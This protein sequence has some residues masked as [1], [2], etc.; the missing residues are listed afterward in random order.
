MV[1]GC[2]PQFTLDDFLMWFLT[3]SWNVDGRAW[4]LN[5]LPCNEC[6]ETMLCSTGILKASQ[7]WCYMAIPE[8]REFKK[9]KFS[10][11]HQRHALSMI[12]DIFVIT[13]R[14]TCYYFLWKKLNFHFWFSP[15]FGLCRAT[16]GK[17]RETSPSPHPL[18]LHGAGTNS[19]R[20]DFCAV[21]AVITGR[22]KWSFLE[23][24]HLPRHLARRSVAVVF[25]AK[26]QTLIST[27]DRLQNG[28][29]CWRWDVILR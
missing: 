12:F 4:V 28:N 15:I 3:H 1:L 13:Y 6:E 8:N 24:L 14:V 16:P 29:I 9:W 11:F 5:Q 19:G 17:R 23:V 20:R 10:F 21:K 18:I 26:R 22:K 7:G 27:V 25:G 2:C